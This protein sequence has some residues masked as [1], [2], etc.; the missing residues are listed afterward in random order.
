MGPCWHS[1]SSR[2]NPSAPSQL[3]SDTTT[4]ITKHNFLTESSG[5]LSKKQRLLGAAPLQA[6][7]IKQK[8]CQNTHFSSPPHGN[9]RGKHT[10]L[11]F[12]TTPAQADRDLSPRCQC[13][14]P[15]VPGRQSWLTAGVTLAAGNMALCSPLGGCGQPEAR[16]VGKDTG[17]LR[18]ESKRRALYPGEMGHMDVSHPCGMIPA[19]P[20]PFQPTAVCQKQQR[21]KEP[22]RREEASGGLHVQKVVRTGREDASGRTQQVPGKKH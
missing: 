4:T 5:A 12:K 22:S 7:T 6:T 2:K 10:M 15:L 14:Q 9:C 11:P 17:E 8:I 19:P 21:Q 3:W 13:R 18:R 1:Y 16:R 20:A